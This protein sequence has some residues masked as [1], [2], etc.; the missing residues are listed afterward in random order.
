MEC[1]D[2]RR[3][4]LFGNGDFL[5]TENTERHGRGGVRGC[6][7]VA[8]LRA[9]AWGIVGGFRF[10]GIPVGVLNENEEIGIR[11]FLS[12]LLSGSV[13]ET[14]W[15]RG[16]IIQPLLIETTGPTRKSPPDNRRLTLY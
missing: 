1:A 9:C 6:H 15:V 4:G 10:L 11:T 14:A 8:G 3:L 5:S 7:G 13:L 12:F 2:F 16:L